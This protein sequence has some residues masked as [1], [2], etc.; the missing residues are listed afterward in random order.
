ME[1]AQESIWEKGSSTNLVCPVCKRNE[2]TQCTGRDVRGHK[3]SQVVRTQ[4]G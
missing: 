3:T 1:Q 4:L 2:W